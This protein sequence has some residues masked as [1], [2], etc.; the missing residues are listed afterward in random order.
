MKPWTKL[1][2]DVIGPFAK[3][4]SRRGIHHGYQLHIYSSWTEARLC[5]ELTAVAVIQ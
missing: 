5:D 1:V 2:M 4:S 3:L